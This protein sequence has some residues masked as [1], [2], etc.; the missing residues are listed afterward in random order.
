MVLNQGRTYRAVGAELNIPASTIAN[1]ARRM[2][3]RKRRTPVMAAPRIV[4]PKA[5]KPVGD[6]ITQRLL[7][8]FTTSDLLWELLRRTKEAQ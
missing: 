3:L 2:R 6:D 4:K 1:Y 8:A 7:G 5:P